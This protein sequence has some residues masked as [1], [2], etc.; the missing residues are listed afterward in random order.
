MWYVYPLR[1]KNTSDNVKTPLD[2]SGDFA[3]MINDTLGLTGITTNNKKHTPPQVVSSSNVA[4]ASN[5]RHDKNM[6]IAGGTIEESSTDKTQNIKKSE[7]E[8]EDTSYLQN[9]TLN[10]AY[11]DYVKGEQAVSGSTPDPE[12]DDETL[13]NAKDMGLAL[14]EDEEH[15]QELGL[16]RDVDKSEEYQKTH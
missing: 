10:S 4:T 2:P 15:P 6:E 12:S 11:A 7:E 16:G 5:F 14:N 3:E 8:G 9:E 13:I 1:M